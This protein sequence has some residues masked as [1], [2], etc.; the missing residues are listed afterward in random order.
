MKSIIVATNNPGKAREYREMLSPL[1]YEVLTPRELGVS[2]DPEETGKTYRENSL[3][4]ARSLRHLVP[5][6]VIADD[7]GFEVE[8]LGGFPGLFTARFAHSFGDDYQKAGLALNEKLGNNPNR[9]ARFVCCICLLKEE[10]G[11]PLYFEGECQGTLLPQM[12][13]KGGFGYDPFFHSN[14]IDQDFGAISDEE[15]NAVSHRGKAL[16]KLL[17]YLR[18]EAKQ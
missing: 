7:S 16:Q 3:I 4:K 2:S 15:K 8:A 11:E 17:S 1:G 10:G 9:K 5:H 6:P 12:V 13:G 14:E 18:E